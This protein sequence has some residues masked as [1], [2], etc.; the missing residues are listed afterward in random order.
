MDVPLQL[1][2]KAPPE[3]SASEGRAATSVH[4]PRVFSPEDFCLGWSPFRFLPA[5]AAPP[6]IKAAPPMKAAPGSAPRKVTPMKAAPPTK[7]APGSA[8]PSLAQAQMHCILKM[9]AQEAHRAKFAKEAAEAAT[10]AAKEA[11]EDP[12][13]LT[14]HI[15][16]RDFLQ[17]A[18]EAAAAKEA[19]E[20]Q[21]AK[22]AAEDNKAKRR[23][24]KATE[25]FSPSPRPNC[26]I[27]L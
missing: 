14:H 15:S 27:Q 3:S 18:A 13:A 7:A 17:E 10:E 24:T 8:P 5:K 9:A 16:W 26:P 21:I 2:V 6:P 23:Q 25:Y 11:A 22:E 12:Q 19:A 1:A 4:A 20:A